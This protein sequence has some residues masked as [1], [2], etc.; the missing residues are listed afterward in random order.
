MS[1][2]NG[3]EE[4]IRLAVR[5]LQAVDLAKRC[6]I[7]GLSLP[8]EGR[9][10]LRAFGKDYIL[11]PDFGLLNAHTGEDAK[12]DIRILVLHYLLYDMP[13]PPGGEWITFREFPGGQ[14]YWGPFQS[15]TAAPLTAKI[16]NDLDR[17]RQNLARFDWEPV[18]HG[19]LGARI[20]IIGKLDLYLVYHCGDEEFPPAV[21]ILFDPVTKRIFSTDDAAALASRVCLGLL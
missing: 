13:V 1:Q 20:H 11:S 8:E 6:P 14:F 5:K 15:R 18:L 3:R 4:A 10:R 2:Q 9:I 17:L 21:D 16:G 19:D 12:P 7:L